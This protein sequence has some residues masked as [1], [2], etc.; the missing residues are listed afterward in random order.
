MQ[1]AGEDAGT[2]PS[3]DPNVRIW[4]DPVCDVPTITGATDADTFYGLGYT[5][6]QDR[7]LQMEAFRHVGHG[8]LAALTGASGLAMEAVRRFSEGSSALQREFDA[9]PVARARLRRF[10]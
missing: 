9:L 8:T 4:R 6:A 1:F 5:M 2:A 7:L 3:G 10:V